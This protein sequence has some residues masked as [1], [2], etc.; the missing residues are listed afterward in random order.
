MMS[1]ST[2][3]PFCAIINDGAP[4]TDLRRHGRGVV[5]FVPLGPVT[6]GHR[7]FVT[8]THI[9]RPHPDYSLAVGLVAELA[10]AHGAHLG[11]D[12]NLIINSGPDATQTIP[13]LH[14]HVVPRRPGDGLTLPWTG[15]QR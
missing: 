1:N 15:Q 2:V 4:V 5:S 14:W 6:E 11:C 13:H 3:C 10:A 7:L 8:E 12:F 9:D